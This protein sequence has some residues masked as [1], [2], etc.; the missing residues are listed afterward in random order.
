MLEIVVSH[1]NNIH[2]EKFLTFFNDD[3]KIIIYDKSNSYENTGLEIKKIKNEGREGETYLRHI[4]ENYDNLCEYTLFIQD[5]TNNHIISNNLFYNE[6][7]KIMS[8]NIQYYQYKVSWR[9]GGCIHTRTVNNGNC[10]VDSAFPS[11]SSIKETCSKH[12]IYLPTIYRTETCAFF[13]VHKN[14]ILKRSKEFYI[15]LR[16]WL[17]EDDR[18]GYVLEHIWCLIFC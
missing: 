16:L 14:V 5:D 8:D 7:Q 6:T 4:I 17:L 11:R 10:D 3:T 15:N 1:Y 9:E 13:I 12:N 2:F 18:N